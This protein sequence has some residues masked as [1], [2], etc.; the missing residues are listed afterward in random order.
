MVSLRSSQETHRAAKYGV[1]F[2]NKHYISA[3]IVPG[4]NYGVRF[5]PEVDDFIE[6][7]DE[8]GRHVTRAF[9]QDTVSKEERN[10][11][12]AQ[13]ARLERDHRAV[14][15]GVKAHRR[16]L[17]ALHNSDPESYPSDHQASLRLEPSPSADPELAAELR[18]TRVPVQNRIPAQSVESADRHFEKVMAT[19]GA[20]ELVAQIRSLNEARSTTEGRDE[21]G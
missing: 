8:Q 11:V 2:R 1:Q 6:L 16:K 21:D 14:E 20:Q 4:T 7:F 17:A 12:L 9:L 15:E 19:P 10:K 3:D 5:L 18:R 13:R